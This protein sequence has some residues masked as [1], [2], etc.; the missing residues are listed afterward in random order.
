MVNYKFQEI[1]VIGTGSIAINIAKYCKQKYGNTIFIE[2]RSAIGLSVSKSCETSNIPFFAFEKTEI[3][4]FLLSLKKETLVVSASN[5]Y[6]FPSNVIEKENL[7]I[8]NY[9]SSLL[10]KYPGRNAEA[11]TIYGMEEKGGITWHKVVKEVDKGDIIFQ[12][13]INLTKLTTSFTLLR[14]YST[15]AFEGFIEFE[16]DLMRNEVKLTPQDNFVKNK[17][18]FSKDLPNNGL[19][20]IE[21]KSEEISAFLRSM[22][23]GPL[24]TLGY[25]KIEFGGFVYSI[26]KYKITEEKDLVLDKKVKFDNNKIELKVNNLRFDLKELEILI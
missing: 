19:L 16:N 25:P 17:H 2:S 13:G 7:F 4:Q 14:Q 12:R 18:Y 24:N 6:L 3:D 20:N 1:I 22:D 23:Y 5:R 15:M 10:P 21:W 26:R 9:H 11:W 8:I